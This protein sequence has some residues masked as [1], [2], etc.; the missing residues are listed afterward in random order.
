M[1]QAIN[2]E[3][4]ELVKATQIY[5]DA[6]YLT[7]KNDKWYAPEDEILN[8]EKLKK[9]GKIKSIKD[10]GVIYVSEGKKA[11]LKRKGFF[12]IR[13]HFNIKNKTI[14]GI[15][16]K[17]QDLIHNKIL[18]WLFNYIQSNEAKLELI[19]STYYIKGKKKQNKINI[20]DL[21]IN[22]TDYETTLEITNGKKVRADVFQ[23]FYKRHSFFGEGIIFEIQL[24]KQKDEKEEERT[25]DR[26]LSGFSVCWLNLGDFDKDE[27]E[28]VLNK[29]EIYLEPFAEIIK[30]QSK[31]IFKKWKDTTQENSRIITE[32]INEHKKIISNKLNEINLAF[33][34][35]ERTIELQTKK[36]ESEL[37]NNKE[38]LDQINEETFNNFK[39]R[40]NTFLDKI[41][42]NEIYEIVK[43]KVINKITNE[44]IN[45]FQNMMK[46][47]LIEY[48]EYANNKL[49]EF[50]AIEKVMKDKC[51]LCGSNMRYNPKG[52]Y[53]PFIGCSN[54][55][56]C[57]WSLSLKYLGVEN[58]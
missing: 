9:E 47:Q 19:Y 53:G 39:E 30:K 31:T 10:I 1:F 48:K 2:K 12:L 24:T 57:K 7:P 36:I 44:L 4:D 35:K 27:E 43:T 20:K 29:N 15:I 50:H 18:N 55:P 45:K 17:P 34:I 33:Q 5:K 41:E 25:L 58:D 16:T 49:K 51:P 8:T 40:Q 3:T 54:Y 11:Y 6:S 32:K 52:I 38:I 21:P 13:P 37:D 46:N 42:D 56:N 14:L 26:A 23:K 28:F 22:I